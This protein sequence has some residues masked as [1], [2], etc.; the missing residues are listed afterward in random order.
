M[1]GEGVRSRRTPKVYP[2]PRCSREFSGRCFVQMPRSCIPAAFILGVLRLRAIISVEGAD[3]RG[4]P[5]RMTGLGCRRLPKGALCPASGSQT[6]R[7][8]RGSNGVGRSRPL[9]RWGGLCGDSGLGLQWGGAPRNRKVLC[10]KKREKWAA[11][12]SH[13]DI[14]IVIPRVAAPLHR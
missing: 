10:A 14:G 2:L 13:I 5:L 6:S 12:R 3:G 1:A 7:L 9:A 11:F 8:T 4:A